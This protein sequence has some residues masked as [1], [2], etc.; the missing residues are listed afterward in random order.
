MPDWEPEYLH[1]DGA[2][3]RAGLVFRTRHGD[4]E[5][6]WMVL[7]HDAADCRARR[8]NPTPVTAP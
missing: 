5:T 3:C 7:D 1:P 6:T 2:R 8:F 4:E